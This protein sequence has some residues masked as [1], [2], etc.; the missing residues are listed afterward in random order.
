MHPRGRPDVVRHTIG[1]VAVLLV[2]PM[3]PPA[4]VAKLVIVSS[5]G[6]S[7]GLQQL[8]TAKDGVPL[9][10]PCEPMM[11]QTR[12]RIRLKQR[13]NRRLINYCVE[14]CRSPTHRPIVTCVWPRD[15]HAGRVKVPELGRHPR[16]SAC[17]RGQ[18]GSFESHFAL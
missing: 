8:G 2:Y 1:R 10:S 5:Y 4:S 11:A 17:P 3:L 6:Q 12:L 7:F 14:S 18:A 13:V 16:F 9:T 15:K